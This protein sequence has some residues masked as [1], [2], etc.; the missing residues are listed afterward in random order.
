MEDTSITYICPKCHYNTNRKLRFID[1]IRRTVPCRPLFS[2]V[3]LAP[4]I[5]E[6]TGG[7][8][9]TAYVCTFPGCNKYY[10]HPTSLSRH[11]DT[12]GPENVPEVD[13]QVE[14]EEGNDEDDDGDDDGD[15]NGDDNGDNEDDNKVENEEDNS[16]EVV[17]SNGAGKTRE[18]RV[19]VITGPRMFMVKVGFWRSKLKGLRARYFTE[20]GDEVEIYEC[21]TCDCILVEKIFEKMFEGNKV[22]Q[23]RELYDKKY[24]E[25]YK[26]IVK[27]LCE[28]S[29]DELKELSACCLRKAKIDSVGVMNGYMMRSLM[30]GC[31]E[32]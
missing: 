20:L 2:D 14:V 24:L 13:N 23:K 19:Y 18:G 3:S 8:A 31:N 28:L 11:R 22:Y 29:V 12:H 25:Y 21:T 27:H 1:H 4:L 30:E 32:G 9:Q 17:S 7:A 15:D 10:W 5:Y 26:F 6:M 16:T